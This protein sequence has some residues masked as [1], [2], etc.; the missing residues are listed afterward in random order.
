MF[1]LEDLQA[2]LNA[3][4][5]VP[6]RLYLSHGGHVDVP[7]PELVLPGRRFALVGLLDPNA[8][9][10]TFDRYATVWYLHVAKHEM[11]RPGS[12]PFSAP[13]EPTDAP[14]PSPA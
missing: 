2:L 14:A 7:G 6:F 3:R 13:P 12:R 5:F 10:T 9:D 1:T 11:L 8:R 4:P